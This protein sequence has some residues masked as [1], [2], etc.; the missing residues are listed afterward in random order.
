MRMSLT[1][2]RFHNPRAAKERLTVPRQMGGRGLNDINRT[3]DKQVQLLQIY[4]LNIQ[5]T[6]SLHVAVVNSDDM[7]TPLYLVRE[8]TNELAIDKEYNSKSRDNGPKNPCM[9]AILM[10]SANNT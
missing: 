8:N 6:S 3:H 2:Y 5:V 1:R 10:T 4:F 7:C 9:A